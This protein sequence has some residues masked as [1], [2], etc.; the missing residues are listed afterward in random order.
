MSLSVNA[1][2]YSYILKSEELLWNWNVAL[3]YDLIKAFVGTGDNGCSFNL[4]LFKN[5]MKWNSSEMNFCVY[6]DKVL[7]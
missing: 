7:N 3:I 6:F 4:I 2:R 1:L 5:I